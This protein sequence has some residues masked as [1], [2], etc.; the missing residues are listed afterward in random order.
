MRF[1]NVSIKESSMALCIIIRMHSLISYQF[2]HPHDNSVRAHASDQIQ[3][4]H[5]SA[6]CLLTPA[7]Y[8]EC[9][10]RHLGSITRTGKLHCIDS[11]DCRSLFTRSTIDRICKIA[12]FRS[13]RFF[14]FSLEKCVTNYRLICS[15]LSICFTV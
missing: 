5:T 3:V 12:W 13:S 4:L 6:L 15:N 7:S 8:C 14:I 1:F 2:N 9:P 10:R 11:V